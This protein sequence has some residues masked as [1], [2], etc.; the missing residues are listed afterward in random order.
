[1]DEI[2]LGIQT[3]SV[4]GPVGLQ[5][6]HE[7]LTSMKDQLRETARGDTLLTV[8]AAHLDKTAHSLGVLHLLAAQANELSEASLGTFFTLTKEFLEVCDAQQV[9][10]GSGLFVA[11]CQKFTEVATSLGVPMQAIAPMRLAAE[12]LL[13][14]KALPRALTPMDADVLQLCLSAGHY[15]LGLRHANTLSKVVHV[16]SPKLSHLTALDFLRFHFYAG[17]VCCGLKKW[18]R[19]LENLKACVTCPAH[20]ASS[21]AVEAYKKLVLV[22]L[23]HLGCKPSLPPYTSASVSRHLKSAAKP[24]DLLAAK[25]EDDDQAGLEAEMAKEVDLLTKDK[26]TGLAK[27]VVVALKHRRLQRLTKCFITLSLDDIAATVGLQGGALEAKAELVGMVSKGAIKASIDEATG[28]VRFRDESDESGQGHSAAGGGGG[29]ADAA[30]GGGGGGGRGVMGS[31]VARQASAD[32]AA[33][34]RLLAATSAVADLAKRVEELDVGLSKN[35][36]YLSKTAS[37][38]DVGGGGRGVSSTAAFDDDYETAMAMAE[39]VSGMD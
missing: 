32:A 9:C 35:P 34:Q 14:G 12:K 26:N 36:A 29:A 15:P 17:L 27:Q 1:M 31:E 8:V 5:E 6:L 28:M 37:F 20:A 10:V 25:F 30:A 39:S 24:Y 3:K 13:A 33:V 2:V 16:G 21:V 23:V 11:L 22:S 18:A 4:A 38:V 7:T 19:A